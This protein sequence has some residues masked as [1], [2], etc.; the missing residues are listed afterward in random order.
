MVTEKDEILTKLQRYCA[1]QERCHSEVRS[2]LISLKVYGDLL[3][4]VITELIREDYL[5]EMRYA[6]SFAG[7]RFRIKKWGRQKIT[8]HLKAKKVSEYCI[9][10]ALKEIDED[11][12]RK[13]LSSL[14]KKYKQERKTLKLNKLQL[15]KNCVQYCINKGYEYALVNE[16]LN[17]KKS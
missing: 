11:D 14:I 9:K 4:E 16:I 6:E 2:K 17:G 15:N 13:T 7:G 8:M 10:K 1:Y 3:E 5:N 12:Y